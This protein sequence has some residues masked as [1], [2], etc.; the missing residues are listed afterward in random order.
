VAR[1]RVSRTRKLS[2]FTTPTSRGSGTLQFAKASATT[3]SQQEKSASADVQ[4]GRIN[5]SGF[6]GTVARFP[7]RRWTFEKW[8]VTQNLGVG[9]R[10]PCRGQACG[11]MLGAMARI[12]PALPATQRST[13]KYSL[14]RFAQI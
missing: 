11:S 2:G 12:A 8:N 14:D 10:R 9:L 3:L 7:S 1:E 13:T 4:R 6:I 5:M